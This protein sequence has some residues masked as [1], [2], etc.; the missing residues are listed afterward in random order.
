MSSEVPSRNLNFV[1]L[2]SED[3]QGARELLASSATIVPSFSPCR[4][5]IELDYYIL[6]RQ[7]LG[8]ILAIL[9]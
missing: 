9:K 2:G 7:R 6:E 8:K 1:R 4:F 3:I 5:M